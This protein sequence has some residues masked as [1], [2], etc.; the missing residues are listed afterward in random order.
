MVVC[1]TATGDPPA[2]CTNGR[3]LRGREAFFAPSPA[4]AAGFQRL[5]GR[6]GFGSALVG[7]A[8][9]GKFPSAVALNPAT[10]TIYVADG[11]NYSGPI[12]P[13]DT[14]SVIDSRHCNTQERLELPGSVADDH[15]RERDSR[16]SAERDRGRRATDTVYVSNYGVNTVSV[17]NGATCNAMVRVW[18]RS[19]PDLGPG[20]RQPGGSVR[21]PP[22]TTPCMSRT[23]AIRRC[24]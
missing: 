18:M 3:S 19:D 1:A 20:R 24:R 14:V 22:I 13:G 8:P 16:R 23:R 15:G 17:V 10:H 12:A 9:A 4:R 7:S 5:G 21:R 2:C 11:F 6:L